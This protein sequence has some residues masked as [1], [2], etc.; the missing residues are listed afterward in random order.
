MTI[1]DKIIAA[2]RRH[3]IPEDL[4]LRQARQ[5]SGMRQWKADGS[6]VVSSA[7]ALGVMQLMPA[8]AAELGV[9]PYDVDQN[10]E[11]GMRYLAQMYRQFGSWPLALAAYNAGPGNMRKVLAG[12]K[13]LPAETAN[14][15]LAITGRPLFDQTPGPPGF[16]QARRRAESPGRTGSRRPPPQTRS[17]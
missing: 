6:I 11:G 4:A 12:T 16:R 15:V 9:N 8:T 1:Q 5:E 17:S 2:A 14:Y 10:I 3:S 7:G 13:T